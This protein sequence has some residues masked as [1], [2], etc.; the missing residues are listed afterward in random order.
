MYSMTCL[1]V[2]F[3]DKGKGERSDL[4]ETQKLEEWEAKYK[5]NKVRNFT[6]KL[7]KEKRVLERVCHS[8]RIW[9]EI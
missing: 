1:Y 2:A 6:R 3:F 7:S 8:V 9:I 5:N 4:H